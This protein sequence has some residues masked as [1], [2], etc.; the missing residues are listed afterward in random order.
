[1]E[2][3]ERVRQLESD[4]ALIRVE[5]NQLL[6]G[7]NESALPGQDPLGGGA[8][9]SSPLEGALPPSNGDFHGSWRPDR[10]RARTAVDL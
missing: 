9:A 4:L 6:A 5:I 10:I 3:D 7:L 8:A 2:L 1:M